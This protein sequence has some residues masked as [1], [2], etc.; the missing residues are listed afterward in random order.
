M[1]SKNNSLAHSKPQTRRATGPKSSEGKA[2]SS[3]N[4]IR[5][6]ILSSRALL[7]DEDPHEFDALLADLAETLRPSGAI[8]QS[9]LERIAITIWRQARL[10]RAE[11]SSLELTRRDDAIAEAVAQELDPLPAFH[12]DVDDIKP[13]DPDRIAF[14]EAVLEELEPSDFTDLNELRVTAPTAYAHLA[15][16][17]E[18]DDVEISVYLADQDKGLN[19]YLSELAHWCRRQ[20]HGAEKRPERIAIAELLRAQRLMPAAE[21]CDLLGRYQTTLDNQLY[22]ALRAFRDAQEWRLAT[23]AA[24][25]GQAATSSL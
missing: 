10:V 2:K 24:V 5:H 14:C 25:A 12:V 17:A 16:D 21:L 23:M 7:S 11:T 22:K 1:P 6:G 19:S 8:E 15:S 4:A 20:L 18:D 13:I 9:L 3:G